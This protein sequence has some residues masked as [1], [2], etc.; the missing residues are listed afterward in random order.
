M[1]MNPKPRSKTKQTRGEYPKSY[2]ELWKPG[3]GKP[4]Q[5]RC[6]EGGL[7]PDRH[8]SGD[9]LGTALQD[10]CAPTPGWLVRA[11]L[12]AQYGAGMSGPWLTCHPVYLV[13]E[14]SPCLPSDGP[15][16]IPNMQGILV[17]RENVSPTNGLSS[18]PSLVS[19]KQ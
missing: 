9:A 15:Q 5:G 4:S 1:G 12:R 13:G 11:G 7:H 3:G 10:V 19:I 14:L 2:G 16:P 6:R 8:P 17:F 18:F